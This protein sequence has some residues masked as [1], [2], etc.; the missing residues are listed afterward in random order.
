MLSATPPPLAHDRLAGSL[1][2]SLDPEQRAA[3]TLP[4]GPAPGVPLAGRRRPDL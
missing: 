4:D 2:A 3:A 1:V